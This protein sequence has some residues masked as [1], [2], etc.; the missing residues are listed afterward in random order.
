MTYSFFFFY[1]FVHKKTFCKRTSS[2]VIDGRTKSTF[3]SSRIT[4]KEDINIRINLK[5][6]FNFKAPR[7]HLIIITINFSLF[8]Y[9]LC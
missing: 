3:T 6:Y 5:R 7:K 4:N 9:F 2:C 1:I 8:L